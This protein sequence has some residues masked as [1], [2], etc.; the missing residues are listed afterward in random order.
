MPATEHNLATPCLIYCWVSEQQM[1]AFG[2]QL[3]LNFCIHCMTFSSGFYCQSCSVT[4]CQEPYL[5]QWCQEPYLNQTTRQPLI[6]LVP[7]PV[8]LPTKKIR[9]VKQ[10]SFLINLCVLLFN[11]TLIQTAT[12]SLFVLDFLC[13]RK[14]GQK[15]PA[16][17]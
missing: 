10:D 6:S 5:N 3:S 9:L 13:L 1:K 8:M 7:R 2:V 16:S 15:K 17:Q 14:S 12:N 11:S 4:R